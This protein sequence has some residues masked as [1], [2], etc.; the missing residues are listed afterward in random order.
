MRVTRLLAVSV[1]LSVL[2]HGAG[3]VHAQAVAT[4]LIPATFFPAHVKVAFQP[5]VTNE[6]MDKAWG[7][8]DFGKPFMHVSPEGTLQRLS[9]WMETGYRQHKQSYEYFTVYVS[10]YGT[11]LNHPG[12]VAAFFDWQASVGGF[13]Q[14]PLAKSQPKALIPEGTPGAAETRVVS[15][16]DGGPTV[17]IAGWWGTTHE[18]EA[19]AIFTPN[20]MSVTDAKR[21]LATMVRYAVRLPG[22]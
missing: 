1:W 13:W 5:N 9:G 8:D 10:T 4:P 19:L 14:V 18:V 15:A 2:V 7:T 20:I 12:N 21:M 6:A 22:A 16:K 17:T 3:R 11:L